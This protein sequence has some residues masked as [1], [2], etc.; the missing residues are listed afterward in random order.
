MGFNQEKLIEYGMDLIDTMILK[1]FIDFK[2]TER[3]YTESKEGINYYWIRYDWL[4]DDIPIISISSHDSLRRRL[5]KMVDAGVLI[6]F[7]KKT[8]KGT[9]AFYNIGENYLSLLSES[10]SNSEKI[11]PDSKVGIAPDSKVG[12]APD[13]KV[14]TNNVYTN[15]PFT[16]NQY[17][18]NPNTNSKND[19]KSKS[20]KSKSKVKPFK[21]HY[22]DNEFV[23]LAEEEYKKLIAK[24][25][26][27][28][29]KEM[30]E[31][32]NL[33]KG[34]TGKKYAS[35][36][37]TILNWLNKESKKQ[38]SNNNKNNRGDIYDQHNPGW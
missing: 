8:F 23:L 12:I 14:G 32:L 15:N 19:S 36:Y 38:T 7:T 30:I 4:L 25:G 24:I 21:I 17:T 22:F 10:Q 11:A 6:H 16:N 26:E 28:K 1:Y 2:G 33:Y 13:S 3:M 37:M 31:R 27:N 18:N 35:D 20:K 34:S 9:Y 29:T 5:K